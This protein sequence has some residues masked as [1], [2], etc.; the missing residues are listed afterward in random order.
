M[1]RRALYTA[2]LD[3]FTECPEELLHDLN[4]GYLAFIYLSSLQ[5][6]KPDAETTAMQCRAGTVVLRHVSCQTESYRFVYTEDVTG[7]SC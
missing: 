3:E 2:A 5:R 4:K 7:F 1:Q 6:R